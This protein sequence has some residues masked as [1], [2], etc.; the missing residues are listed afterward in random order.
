MWAARSRS[1]PSTPRRSS[2]P[3]GCALRPSRERGRCPRRTAEL[4]RHALPRDLGG[5]LQLPPYPRVVTPTHIGVTP[6][7]DPGV[8]PSSHETS[9]AEMMDRRGH[10]P[11]HARLPTR[12]ARDDPAPG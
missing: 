8:H 3:D 4:R 11:V 1:A 5:L 2:P 9:F 7:L 12:Y 6:G 10:K